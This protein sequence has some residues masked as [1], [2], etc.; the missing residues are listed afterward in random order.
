LLQFKPSQQENRRRR[1]KKKNERRKNEERGRKKP[2][3]KPESF[4]YSQFKLREFESSSQTKTTQ[5]KK[6]EITSPMM[7]SHC[8]NKYIVIA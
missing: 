3:A 8:Q 2:H 7:I 4:S 1:G 6:K 5:S